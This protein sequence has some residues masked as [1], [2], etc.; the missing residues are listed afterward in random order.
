MEQKLIKPV[1]IVSLSN[2]IAVGPL[3]GCKYLKG[4]HPF[5]QKCITSDGIPATSSICEQF[6]FRGMSLLA[7]IIYKGLVHY[8][9]NNLPFVFKGEDFFI[10]ISAKLIEYA[11]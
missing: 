11:F 7:E 10:Y 9:S 4:N 3:R 5:C 2:P 6:I 1:S 8:E